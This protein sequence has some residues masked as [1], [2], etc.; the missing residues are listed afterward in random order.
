MKRSV[1]LLA[2]SLFG[3]SLLAT[4]GAAAAPLTTEAAT[5]KAAA[6]DTFRAWT[7]W[8]LNTLGATV[9]DTYEMKADTYQAAG[10]VAWVSGVY[11]IVTRAKCG[12]ACCTRTGV[13]QTMFEKQADGSWKLSTHTMIPRP[14]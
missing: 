13:F 14:M 12:G 8:H 6:D 4:V 2:A 9:Y 10:D 5:L 3:G 1:L 7:D 11:T